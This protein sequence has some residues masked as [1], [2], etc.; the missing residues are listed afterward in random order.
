[1]EDLIQQGQYNIGHI[2]SRFQCDAGRADKTAMRFID[3]T[4]A[5]QDFTFLDLEQHSNRFAN[6]LESLGF[7]K[8]DI[9]FTFLPKVSGTIFCFY[10]CF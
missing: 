6:V 1:M 7:S 9:I 2:C 8:G 3:S 5:C 10:R 4:F